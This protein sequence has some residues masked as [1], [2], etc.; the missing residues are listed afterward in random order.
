MITFNVTEA[1]NDVSVVTFKLTPYLSFAHSETGVVEDYTYEV[2]KAELPKI[3]SRKAVVI[4]GEGP[5][6]V[7]GYLV[8]KF[9]H[10]RWTGVWDVFLGGAVVVS[11][12]RG[13]LSEGS[14]VKV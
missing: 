11:N 2:T 14:I 1:T 5:A 6:W 8:E 3:D 10:C 7:T 9:D 13:G 4:C 12:N